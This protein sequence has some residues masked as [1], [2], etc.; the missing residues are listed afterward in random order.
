[1]QSLLVK[2]EGDNTSQNE[3][4]TSPANVNEILAD[5]PEQLLIQQSSLIPFGPTEYG[6]VEAGSIFTDPVRPDVLLEKSIVFESINFTSF[7][8]VNTLPTF[9]TV[10][11]TVFVS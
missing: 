2:Y 5:I 1:M 6:S 8:I 3:F 11:S 9:V 7:L 4:L 10:I